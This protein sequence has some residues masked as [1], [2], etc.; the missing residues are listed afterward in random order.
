[1]Q[2]LHC[3]LLQ[4]GNSKDVHVILTNH[5]ELSMSLKLLM[6]RI[7]FL[8]NE[9][10]SLLLFWKIELFHQEI[11]FWAEE[12]HFAWQ[13]HHWFSWTTVLKLL[14]QVNDFMNSALCVGRIG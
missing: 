7:G 2:K 1:M 8:T 3:N 11:Q 14:I 5:K 4:Q 9:F 13:L 12:A 6:D 10:L